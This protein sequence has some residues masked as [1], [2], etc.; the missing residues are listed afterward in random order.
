MMRKLLLAATALSLAAS[1]VLAQSQLPVV[2]DSTGRNVQ[3]S[4]VLTVDLTGTYVAP[5]SGAGQTA[6]TTAINNM[7]AAQGASTAGQTEQL[8]AC[9]VTTAAPTYVTATTNPLSCDTSGNLR[10]QSVGQYNTT[11]PTLTNGQ[12][13]IMQFTARNE[14]VASLSAGGFAIGGA[15]PAADGITTA[16]STMVGI[17]SRSVVY[18]LG[19]TNLDRLRT[20]Q[21]SDGTG[22]GIQA[23]ANAPVSVAAGAIVPS[24]SASAA[25]TSLI[26]KASAGNYYDGYCKSSVVGNCIAYN[27]ATVP[28]AGALTASL[29][30]EC[31]PILTAGGVASWSYGTMPRRASAGIVYLFSSSTDCNTYTVSA[32]AYIHGSVQ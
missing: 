25:S 20:I 2:K 7:S 9:A 30:L 4:G 5:A 32:T 23:V 21:G 22:L 11:L 10:A 19:P 24:V 28:A 3:A 8:V 18:G 1:P 29:V 17:A 14:L 15:N 27:S 26:L 13:G 16:S 6:T 12:Y 31:A